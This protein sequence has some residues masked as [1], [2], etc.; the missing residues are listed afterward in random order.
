M[1]LNE[2]EADDKAEERSQ[3]LVVQEA[4]H[5]AV[6]VEPAVQSTAASS[7]SASAAAAPA[8]PAAPAAANDKKSQMC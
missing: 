6:F 3:M 8:A 5:H 4:K 7:S 1:F 2:L